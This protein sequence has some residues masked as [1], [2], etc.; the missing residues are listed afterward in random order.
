MKTSLHKLR[1][2]GI[3]MMISFGFLAV[4]L[5]VPATVQAAPVDVLQKCNSDS[6]VCKGTDK[7]SLFNLFESVINLLLV[8]IGVIAVIMIVVGGIKYTTSGGDGNATKSA[9][10]TVV[11]AVVGLV[12]AIMSYAIVNFVLSKL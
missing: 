6:Q 11:Y 10:D 9:R 5:I 12:I 4:P 2:L 8:I 1:L 3:S 7:N